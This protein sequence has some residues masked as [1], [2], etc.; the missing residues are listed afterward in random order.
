MGGENF[1][2][3]EHNAS[4]RDRG[5]EHEVGG[6]AFEALQVQC[7]TER[8]IVELDACGDDSEQ[9]QGNV[10]PARRADEVADQLLRAVC[11][12]RRPG[13]ED[14][15][16]G[17]RG[18]PS[19]CQPGGPSRIKVAFGLAWT[20]G[21]PMPR[22]V[23]LIEHGPVVRGSRGLRGL[24]FEVGPGRCPD[25]RVDLKARCCGAAQ[26]PDTSQGWQNRL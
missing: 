17:R 6:N 10:E 5:A 9:K 18:S 7:E 23:V 25:A 3:R 4:E 24:K 21:H 16:R 22:S 20:A 2:E 13:N 26:P 8:N 15:D 11:Q 19:S 14:E 12:R 1:G